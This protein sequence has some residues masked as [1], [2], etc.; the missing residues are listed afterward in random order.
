MT[1]NI[2]LLVVDDIRTDRMIVR[3]MLEQAGVRQKMIF[4]SDCGVRTLEFLEVNSDNLDAVF[5]DINMPILDGITTATIIKKVY[6][7]L[8]IIGVSSDPPD[9]SITVFDDYVM[10]PFSRK[11]F[12]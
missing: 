8:K 5:M 4:F 6:P 10:K 11:Q 12:K 7:K 1:Y 2:Q 9:H 3:T